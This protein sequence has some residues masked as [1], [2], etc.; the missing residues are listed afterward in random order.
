MSYNTLNQIISRIDKENKEH[1]Y[2]YDANGNI[3]SDGIKSYTYTSFNKVSTITKDE[4]IVSTHKYDSFNNLVEKIEGLKTTLYVD[5][6]YEYVTTISKKIE[7]ETTVRLSTKE[8]FKHT[9]FAGNEAVAVHTK[10]LIDDEKQVDKTA[11]VHKDSLGSTDIVTNSQGEII[12]QNRYNPWGALLYSI[13]PSEQYTKEDLK[14]YTGH[15]QLYS[16]NLIDMGGRMY[17]TTIGRFLSVDPLLQDPTNSQNYNRYVYVLSNPLKYI[18]PSGYGL[19][20]S[21]GTGDPNDTGGYSGGYGANG[22][23]GYNG[24]AND[25]GFDS[26]YNPINQK[27]SKP[28]PA[29]KEYKQNTK[30]ILEK[31]W[32]AFTGMFKSQINELKDNPKKSVDL[33]V[34]TILPSSPF[35]GRAPIVDKFFDYVDPLSSL[36]NKMKSAIN[37]TI[38]KVEVGPNTQR[39]NDCYD[40]LKSLEISQKEE[41]CSGVCQ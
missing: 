2:T 20:S 31:A 12:L 3:L 40:S 41:F 7:E 39:C 17:D 36:K 19:A 34:D 6:E 22:N 21:E 38:D 37:K 28:K 25:G 4:E 14:G 11:Y 15:R 16:L 35:P 10:T 5:N 1:N 8:E 13:N 9:V 30:N 29:P 18:D 23:E 27:P 26:K 33:A 32:D 24:G